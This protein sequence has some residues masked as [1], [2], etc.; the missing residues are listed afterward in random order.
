MADFVFQMTKL[1]VWQ[2]PKA[3]VMSDAKK[4]PLKSA[5]AKTVGK[6]YPSP[7]AMQQN[8]SAQRQHQQQKKKL[9]VI[10]SLR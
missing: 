10:T 3:S 2:E 6:S 4:R 1:A 5:A 8:G 9:C 7:A